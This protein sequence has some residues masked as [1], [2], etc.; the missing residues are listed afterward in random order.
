MY[1][2]GKLLTNIPKNF[3]LFVETS[4]I[5]SNWSDERMRKNYEY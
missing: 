2:K 5:N 3:D 1:L 4:I